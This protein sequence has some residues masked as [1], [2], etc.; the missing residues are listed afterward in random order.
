MSEG[1]GVLFQSLTAVHKA[2]S[3]GSAF[4]FIHSPG[5]WS[6]YSW[7]PGAPSLTSRFNPDSAICPCSPP[8][9]L[10]DLPWFSNSHWPF[11]QP[12]PSVR[13]V[14][15]AQINTKKNVCPK[16]LDYGLVFKIPASFNTLLGRWPTK[17]RTRF[18]R[19]IPWRITMPQQSNF[20]NCLLQDISPST[21][22]G[23]RDIIWLVGW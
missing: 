12:N 1:L 10:P 18:K 7:P 20:N 16:R 15:S 22:P 19:K 21:I 6:Q 23:Y 2:S 4:L 5:C 8:M 13:D 14:T 11:D 17:P 3:C 9:P